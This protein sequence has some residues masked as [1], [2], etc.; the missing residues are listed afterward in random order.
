MKPQTYKYAAVR[1]PVSQ[2]T[3]RRGITLLFVV[4]TLVLF[5]L[6]TASFM[7]ISAQFRRST[8]N[9][10]RVQPRRDDARTLVHRVFYD[11]L[12]EVSLDN[13]QSPMRGQS[14][15]GDIYGYGGISY[16][17]NAAFVPN[18]GNQL[19]I[20]ELDYD[21][22]PL[23]V[24]PRPNLPGD[25]FRFMLHRDPIVPNEQWGNFSDQSDAYT[26]QVL[27]FTT[28]LAQGI[29][30]RIVAYNVRFD[31]T[32]TPP[33][34]LAREFVIMPEWNNQQVGFLSPPDLAQS[35]VV[36][37]NKPFSGTGAG[38]FRVGTPIDQAA[39]S[40]EALLPNRRGES[41]VDLINNYLSRRL[42]DNV[43]VVPNHRSTNED[44]VAADF[45]NMYLTGRLFD[46]N[47]NLLI[48]PAFHR[49]RLQQYHQ[50]Y[51][52]ANRGRYMFDAVGNGT[53]VVDNDGDGIADGIWIDFGLPIHRDMRGRIIKPLVSILCLDMD[54]NL[55]VNAHGNPTQ[56]LPSTKTPLPLL[57]GGLPFNFGQGYGPPEI[58][59][60]NAVTNQEYSALL[61]GWA[62]YLGRYGNNN[63]PGEVGRDVAS[64][65]K[66]FSHPAAP[67]NPRGLTG[68]F[69]FSAMDIHGKLGWGTPNIVSAPIPVNP[70][71]P[72]GPTVQIPSSLPVADIL[73]S[74]SPNELHESAYEFSFVSAP[75]A[76]SG[77]SA[78]APY[79]PRELESV[80]RLYDPDNKMLSP[81]LREHLALTLNSGDGNI[82]RN[83]LTTDSFDVP[84]PPNSLIE[85]LETILRQNGFTDQHA[86]NQQVRLMLGPELTKGLRLDVNRPFGNG[87]DDGV[88]DVTT[89]RR[90]GVVD[91]PGEQLVGEMYPDPYGRSIGFDANNDGV[92]D[93]FDTL[94][95]YH[96]AKNLYVTTLLVTQWVDRNGDGNVDLAGDWYDYN[97]D[98]LVDLQDLYDY[99]R[100]VA[101]W[102]V[103]VVD[104]RDADSIMTVTEM[105]LNPWDGWDVDGNLLTDESVTIG[106]NRFVV[107]GCERPELLI[108]EAWALHLRRT[109]DRADDDGDG[110]TVADGDDDRDSRLV[111]NA[112]V[113]VELYNPHFFTGNAIVDANNQI[114][115][116]EL[117]GTTGV[118]LRRVALDSDASLASPV[119]R[120]RFVRAT[121]PIPGNPAAPVTRTDRDVDSF[122]IP[123]NDVLRIVYFVEPINSV[124]RTEYPN[125]VYFPD[126]GI[127]IPELPPGGRA[128]VGS[129]GVQTGNNYTTY[130]G[131]RNTPTWATELA[132]TRRI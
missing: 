97:G 83:I 31:T 79:S 77:F 21:A 15:L 34:L 69:F 50:D 107:R 51:T 18:T 13:T 66:L 41:R 35:R 130:L 36:I 99:R 5:L 25:Q 95:R 115:P 121:N 104:F 46:L 109:E 63:V 33:A 17:R 70:Y 87:V 92:L 60:G 114:Y 122:V 22:A 49:S 112:S 124:L 90:A 81:R 56:V 108:A 23:A 101:Q 106:A 126:A 129:A 120:M 118:D 57:G 59:L 32:V 30:C 3:P 80:L 38:Q 2:R 20:M 39:L 61:F 105:D 29:S 100:D 37:N 85:K 125:K 8:M 28:G 53:P 7:L 16:V 67:F 9:Q 117:Y 89:G 11:L 131:R 52:G 94:A 98:G 110:A 127:R 24:T 96:F 10:M 123:A 65:Y 93:E 44:Y 91:E 72:G 103:N 58:S 113:F 54:G 82:L 14:I 6:L 119:W 78:D 88:N 74:A 71:N 86:I 19:I 47:G 55:N 102:A 111:P 48:E 75:F 76:P 62:G 40:S 43:T 132:D 26:G 128:V 42:A 64:A 73:N 116:P 45:Q 84:V 4:S 1:Q 68:N 12:R 27:T